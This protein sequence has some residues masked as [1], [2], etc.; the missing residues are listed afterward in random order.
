MMSE[1]ASGLRA[2]QGPG[3]AA[4]LPGRLCTSCS[5]ACEKPDEPGNPARLAQPL[6]CSDGLSD[7]SSSCSLD[8]LHNP[9]GTQRTSQCTC[10]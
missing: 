10:A 8:S 3:R 6:G 7:R 5:G 2:G 4:H 1:M 9:L